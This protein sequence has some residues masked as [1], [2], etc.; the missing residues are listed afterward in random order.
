M[1]KKKMNKADLPV[2]ENRR[3]LTL[4][5]GLKCRELISPAKKTHVEMCGK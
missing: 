2:G 3:E 5:S 4:I 1:K